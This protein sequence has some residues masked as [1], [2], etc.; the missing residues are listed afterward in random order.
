M[1]SFDDHEG[2]TVPDGLPPVIDAHVHIFRTYRMLGTE[3]LKN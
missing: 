3:S 2:L 1:L